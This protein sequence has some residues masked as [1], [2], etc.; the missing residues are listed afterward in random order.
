MTDEESG[1]R[2]PIRHEHASHYQPTPVVAIALLVLFALSVV[3][4][5]HYV[6]PVSVGGGGSNATTTTTTTVAHT[7]TTLPKSHVKVQVANGTSVS[8][9]AGHYT[10]ELVV[11]GWDALS[12]IDANH[13]SNT[14]IV[15]YHPG[16]EWAARD[17][18]K[19]L[20]VPA[21]AVTPIGS[22]QPV[23]GYQNDDVIVVVGLDLAH[24]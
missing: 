2:E 17:I 4:V 15:Y 1:E 9:L 18:A 8:G 13:R 23:A 3:G 14:T 19:S 24:T 5:L 21:S 20:N 12:P 22:S 7:T 16:F 10:N 6:S 11:L